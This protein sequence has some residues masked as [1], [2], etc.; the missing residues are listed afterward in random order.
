LQP[1]AAQHSFALIFIGFKPKN[2]KSWEAGCRMPHLGV[3]TCVAMECRH[4]GVKRGGAGNYN[5]GVE[6]DDT[7]AVPDSGDIDAP[8]L[9]GNDDDLVIVKP[10]DGEEFKPSEPQAVEVA[11]AEAVEEVPYSDPCACRHRGHHQLCIV[12]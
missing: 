9:G 12:G 2:G 5:W 10:Q 7:E 8:P 4:E 3:L 6:G 1:F 11:A